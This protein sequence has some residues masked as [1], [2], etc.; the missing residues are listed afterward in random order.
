M[1]TDY[2][3]FNEFIDQNI[4]NTINSAEFFADLYSTYQITNNYIVDKYHLNNLYDIYNSS[5]LEQDAI[6]QNKIQNATN[7]NHI[8]KQLF[9]NE[10]ID[11]FISKVTN[12]NLENY[13]AKVKK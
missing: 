8:L 10:Q 2:L 6:Q 9:T 11:E 1:L 4:L 12:I 13:A 5:K 7:N 3:F